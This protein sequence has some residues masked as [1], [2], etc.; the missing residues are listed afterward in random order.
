M[1]VNILIKDGTKYGGLYIAK[2][3]F[4]DQKVISSG[5][6]PVSVL[7]EAKGKGAEDPVVIFIPKK[8]MV[9]VY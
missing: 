7:E 6:D 3:T 5:D 4:Q 1:P 8:G 2:K 9:N